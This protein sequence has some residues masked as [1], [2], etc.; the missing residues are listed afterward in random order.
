[1]GFDPQKLSQIRTAAEE[2]GFKGEDLEVVCK[3]Q[4]KEVPY[5]DINFEFKEPPTWKGTMKRNNG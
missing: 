5:K 3:K 4:G 1:M 2:N